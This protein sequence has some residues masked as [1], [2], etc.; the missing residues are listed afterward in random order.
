MVTKS[1]SVEILSYDK[2]ETLNVESIQGCSSTGQFTIWA[3]HAPLVTLLNQR[4]SLVVKDRS[5]DVQTRAISNGV[6]IV[7]GD[8]NVQVILSSVL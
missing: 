2:K 1:F 6:L 4:S 8:G 3:E 7:D 5:G